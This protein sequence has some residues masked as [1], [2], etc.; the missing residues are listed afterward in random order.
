MRTERIHTRSLTSL[1][2]SGLKV[3]HAKVKYFSIQC[4]RGFR[5]GRG[6]DFVGV[7]YGTIIIKKLKRGGGDY[8]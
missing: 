8:R 4:D 7:I 2:S 3:V 5:K 1:T 6:N